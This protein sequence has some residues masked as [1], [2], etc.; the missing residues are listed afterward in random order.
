MLE[1]HHHLRGQNSERV[2]LHEKQSRL[3]VLQNTG[4][5]NSKFVGKMEKAVISM[6]KVLKNPQEE[7]IKRW[8]IS[9]TWWHFFKM[10][11]IWKSNNRQE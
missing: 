2:A 11:S 6:L 7:G 5:P 4:K 9:R 8:N 3:F 10:W 1:E